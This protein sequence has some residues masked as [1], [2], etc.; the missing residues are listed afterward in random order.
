VTIQS[1]ESGFRIGQVLIL[2]AKILSQHFLIFFLAGVVASLPAFLLIGRLGFEHS[3]TLSQSTTLSFPSLAEVMV[4]G[5]IQYVAFAVCNA[6]VITPAAFQAIRGLPV[7]VGG[8]LKIGLNRVIPVILL[9]I[10]IVVL[11]GLA[12]LALIVPGLVL[13]TMWCVGTPACVVERTGPLASLKRS[14]QLTKGYR[15]KLFGLLLLL[16]VVSMVVQ[17][18][19][20]PVPMGSLLFGAVSTTYWSIVLVTVYDDLCLIQEGVHHTEAVE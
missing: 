14:A 20:E 12:M 13:L 11:A 16:G 7:S 17:L 8:A 19:I 4:L 6:A 2:S 3:F 15:W 5:V 18:L 9:E 10:V 1:M